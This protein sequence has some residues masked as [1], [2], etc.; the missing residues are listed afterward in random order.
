M[1]LVNSDIG[2]SG[3][4]KKYEDRCEVLVVGWKSNKESSA[5][6]QTRRKDA[7]Q[8]IRPHLEDFESFERGG[9]TELAQHSLEA[10]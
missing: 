2:R 9:C 3:R 6:A 7:R 5:G 4:R 8:L 10:N 1:H